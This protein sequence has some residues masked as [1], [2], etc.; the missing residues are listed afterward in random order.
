MQLNAENTEGGTL[1]LN[2][3]EERIAGQFDLFAGEPE[4][5][6]GPAA[7]PEEAWLLWMVGNR[8]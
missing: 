1:A 2:A 6:R 5:R 8:E 3:H 7:M 4:S